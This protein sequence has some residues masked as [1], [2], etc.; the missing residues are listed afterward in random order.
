MILTS[1]DFDGGNNPPNEDI[2]DTEPEFIVVGSELSSVEYVLVMDTSMSMFT[3][4][5]V[6]NPGSRINSMVDAAKRWVKF[7]LPNDV[8]LGVV[9]FADEEKIIP[10]VNMTQINDGSRD[11][12]VDKLGEVVRGELH[13]RRRRRLPVG[14]VLLE[15]VLHE[16]LSRPR[17]LALSVFVLC[18]VA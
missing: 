14:V 5:D 3:E 2:H 18:G 9:T 8:N 12:L 1:P 17:P 13:H 4:P 10:F 11:A 16:P 15:H 6:T 7:D